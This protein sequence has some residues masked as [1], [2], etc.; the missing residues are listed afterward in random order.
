MVKECMET[1]IKLSESYTFRNVFE[2][3]CGYGDRV[4]AELTEKAKD[5]KASSALFNAMLRG[6]L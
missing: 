3:M 4:A 6:Q 2:I 1:L 5:S